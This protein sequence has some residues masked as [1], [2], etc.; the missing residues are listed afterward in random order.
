MKSQS[1]LLMALLLTLHLFSTVIFAGVYRW[2]DADGKVH[3][4]DRPPSTVE[5]SEELA[6]P[7]GGEKSAPGS[8][9]ASDARQ[10][11]L[12]QFKSEREQ[13]KKAAQKRK[14]AEQ[15]REKKCA[16]ARKLLQ[17]YLEYGLLY[18]KLPGN[19]RRYL[20]DEEREQEIDK[21]RRQEERWCQ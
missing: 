1:I 4:G 7:A 12:E 11:L 16:Q 6:V 5:K 2:V 21:M 8:T 10:R 20:T 17:R 13:K 14:Q 19:K 9:S 15:A 3:F 18:E